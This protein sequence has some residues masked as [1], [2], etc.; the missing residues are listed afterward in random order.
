[1][2]QPEVTW[3]L[4]LLNVTSAAVRLL[5]YHVPSHVVGNVHAPS[6]GDRIRKKQF[7]CYSEAQ[8]F[9]KHFSLGHENRHHYNVDLI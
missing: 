1:M 3:R 7:S 4:A 6:I 8:N 2:V 9:N 5:S